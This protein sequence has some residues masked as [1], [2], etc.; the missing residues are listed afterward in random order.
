MNKLYERGLSYDKLTSN[1]KDFFK[2]YIW[3]G[4]GSSHYTINPHDLIF[5]NAS[6]YHDFNYFRGGNDELRELADSDFINRSLAAVR[7][8]KFYK[9]PFYWVVAYIYYFG[10]VIFG[11]KAWEYYEEPADSWSEFMS[12]VESAFIREGRKY[13]WEGE[14]D[15]PSIIN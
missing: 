10:L 13:P 7:S 15:N 2:K 9:Q 5:K 4:V 14:V 1:Q 12:R 11:K 3:N 8:Q 6:I